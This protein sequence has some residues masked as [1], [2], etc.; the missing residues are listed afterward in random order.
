MKQDYINFFGVP[1]QVYEMPRFKSLS[2][3]AKVLYM[4]MC[5]LKNRFEDGDGYFWHTAEMLSIDTGLSRRT[6]FNAKK[7][8]VAAK[9]IETSHGRHTDGSRHADWYKVNG[10][11]IRIDKSAKSA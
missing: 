10:F 7:E 11:N 2:S 9:F 6:V 4:D 5:R 8:L 3:T 1:H